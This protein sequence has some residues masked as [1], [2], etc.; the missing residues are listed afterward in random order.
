MKRSELI[1]PMSILAHLGIINSIL[2][3]LTPQTY[4][5]FFSIFYYNIAWLL[6]AYGLSFYPTSRKERFFTNI[7]KLFQLYLIY[8][9]AYF[10][11]FSFKR[12]EDISIQFQLKI[13]FFIC[14]CLTIYRAVF[15]WA[16]SK[17]RMSGGNFVNVVVIGRDKN[18]KKIRK[19]F[20]QPDLGYRYQGYFDN[21]P[22]AS[23]TYLG[24]IANSYAYVLENSVDQ[25]FCMVSQ[26]SRDEL[27]NL[28]NLADN[29]FKKLKIISDNKEIFTRAMSIELYDS[30]PVVNLRKL[31]LDLE[32]SRVLKRT[33]DIVFSFL[34]IVFL[35]SWLTPLLYVLIK[36]ESP[37]KI[38]F[39]QKRHGVNRKVFWCY[40]FRSM[41]VNKDSDSL[42]TSKNDLR[43]TR[44]GKILRKTSIDEL[45][46]FFNVFLG[47]M[48]VVG[49]R[50]HME[51]HTHQYETS[52]DKYLVR[53]YV[54]PG[55]TGLAQIK[56]YRGEIIKKADIINRIRYDIFY[57]EK[58]S[59]PLDVEIIY[60]TVT[61]AIKGEEKAY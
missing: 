24:N 49:P 12:V 31:P 9:L 60:R 35:L 34:V 14:L 53:H 59:M 17:Y 29:N 5:D 40:K 15:Y 32:F 20:D 27:N 52:V 50:P 38:F 7:H 8:G 21:Q 16:R 54:K 61:N 13:F 55:I 39:K 10:A 58:W 6:T 45:P 46:Q 42:M 4:L 2:L 48:S 18:L 25:I 36:L 43:V 57:V 1:V 19:V 47:N 37:G 44:I 11:L 30:I 56:G 23:P 28:I 41:T 3:F 51:L 22:S 33:F 26:L